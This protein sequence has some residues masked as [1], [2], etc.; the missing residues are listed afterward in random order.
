MDTTDGLGMSM[1]M[2]AMMR[3]VTS[4]QP[5]APVR[6]DRPARTVRAAGARRALARALHT[7]ADRVEPRANSGT[8]ATA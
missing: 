2:K 1:A 7:V 3:E 5:G 6:P 8:C 4:A